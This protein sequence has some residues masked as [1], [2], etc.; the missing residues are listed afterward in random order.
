[1]PQIKGELIAQRLQINK[2]TKQL[3]TDFLFPEVYRSVL[4]N[5]YQYVNINPKCKLNWADWIGWL[6]VLGL[7]ALETVLQSISDRLPER[8][9]MRR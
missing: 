3:G 8:G 7:A 2:Y 9:R 4:Y 5:G 6:V 1:M